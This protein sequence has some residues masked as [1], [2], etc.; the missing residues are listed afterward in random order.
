MLLFHY[1]TA[2]VLVTL[3]SFACTY[4]LRCR[5]R[6]PHMT[7]G[8]NP[9][10][11][12]TVYSIPCL[13]GTCCVWPGTS[14]RTSTRHPL[15]LESPLT[16]GRSS[17]T[18]PARD[19][20]RFQRMLTQH[21]L[22]A[23]N[24]WR[25]EATYKDAQS[26]ASRVDFI[27]TRLHQARGR[28]VHTFPHVR[29][30][31]WRASAGHVLLGG[32]ISIDVWR[33]APAARAPSGHDRDALCKACSPVPRSRTGSLA[34]G[35]SGSGASVSADAVPS[36][37][38]ETA[39]WMFVRRRFHAEPRLGPVFRGSFLRCGRIFAGWQLRCQL[40]RAEIPR[41]STAL[42]QEIK[43]LKARSKQR[44]REVWMQRLAEGEKALA[45]QDTYAL[46][47]VIQDLAPRRSRERVQIRD[48]QGGIGVTFSARALPPVLLGT[49][50]RLSILR[51]LTFVLPCAVSKDVRL[52]HLAMFIRRSGRR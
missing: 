29:L 20:P 52:L 40:Q 28:R 15:L 12:L 43:Q 10:P 8:T 37:G 25:P 3:I 45:R 27:L 24:T 7:E 1:N 21:Q 16:R 50:N 32:Y 19:Q 35:L 42:G 17:G 39:A 48:A 2:E 23:L 33:M 26:H 41:R 18:L 46:F 30:A 6:S 22:C 44:R 49:W 36:Q 5:N 14:T 34:A 47:Q 9:G 4:L 51:P 31:S 11:F 13:D 38:R